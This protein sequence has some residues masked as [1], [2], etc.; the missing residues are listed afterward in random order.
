[1]KYLDEYRDST[2][3]SGL[4]KE[5]AKIVTR[6]WVLM[7]VCGGQ[8][9]SIV[10]YGIDRMIPKSIELVHGP[11][12]PVC[13]TSLE[14]IDKAHAIASHSDVIFTSFGDMLRVPGS[15]QDL[16]AV[17]SVA[18]PQIAPKL[19]GKADYAFN[20]AAWAPE[21]TQ[22]N[23]VAGA[24]ADAFRARFGGLMTDSSIRDFEA[25]MA[26]GLAIE[27]AD[28]T[29]PTSVQSALNALDVT[30]TITSW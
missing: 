10:R 13:V 7:E 24:V 4:T 28:S 14:M 3:A 27:H 29:D 9:H 5:I 21:V 15:W 22:K 23:P 26:L 17:K 12:C 6:P 20:R 19:G 25:V 18:D 30:R 2:V 1:M 8:T 16:L 11:G